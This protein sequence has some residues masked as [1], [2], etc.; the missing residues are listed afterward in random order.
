M[1]ERICVAVA[2]VLML[3]CSI[4]ATFIS[5]IGYRIFLMTV[6]LLSALFLVVMYIR[7]RKEAGKMR[8]DLS[9]MQAMVKNYEVFRSA[10]KKCVELE[11]RLAAL[12]TIPELDPAQSLGLQLSRLNNSLAIII[13]DY[14]DKGYEALMDNLSAAVRSEELL[15]AFR[16][17][18]VRP[19]MDEL[20]HC[21]MPAS[22]EDITRLTALMMEVAMSS[23]DVV[24]TCRENIN[25]RSEQRLTK[26]VLLGLKTKEQAYAAAK[27]ITDNPFETPVWARVIKSMA[28]QSGV[29]GRPILY[30]GYKIV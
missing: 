15:F 21:E 20:K 6:M 11:N 16:D 26:D 12:E 7:L 23:V 25:A 29:A 30:S 17:K 3:I 4:S 14:K 1:V 24:D 27:I 19:F 9:S 18:V 10:A 5:G 28:V 8:S 2:A 22:S 13:P